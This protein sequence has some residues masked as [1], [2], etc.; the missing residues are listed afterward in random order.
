MWISRKDYDEHLNQVF[1]A[2]VLIQSYKHLEEQAESLTKERD[3][4]S[5]RLTDAIAEGVQQ[6]QKNRLL[7][8]EIERL[9]SRN[10]TTIINRCVNWLKEALYDLQSGCMGQGES[11]IQEVI[12]TLERLGDEK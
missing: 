10:E 8:K 3:D 5:W 7:A 4:L 6:E 1:V 11:L 2:N 9:K 12:E